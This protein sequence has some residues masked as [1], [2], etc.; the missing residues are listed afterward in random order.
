MPMQD[1]P[2]EG[3]ASL[4]SGDDLREEVERQ[5]SLARRHQNALTVLAVGVDD[6]ARVRDRLGEASGEEILRACAETLATRLRSSDLLGQMDAQ[7]LAVILPHAGQRG[8]QEAA[9]RLREAIAHRPIPVADISVTI[10]ASVGGAVFDPGAGG[11]DALLARA[12]AALSRAKAEGGDRCL[13]HDPA[14]PAPV[15]ARRVLKGGHITFNAGRSTIDCTVRWLSDVGATL[16]VA[17]TA[18]IPDAFKLQ[19]EADGL[20]KQCHVLSR[21]D[22]QIEV[23]FDVLPAPPR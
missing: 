17:S 21:R 4:L 11:G 22:G 8:A 7:T 10:T 6:F 14:T 16:T 23:G 1:P 3:R 18:G 13:F 19:I 15:A 20:S 5:I 2:P 9:K 12:A